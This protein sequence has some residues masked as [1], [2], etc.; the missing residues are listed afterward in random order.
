[1][2]AEQSL[3]LP[4]G[5][6]LYAVALP[7]VRE[8]V[9]APATTP[10]PTLSGAFLGLFNLRGEIVPLLDTAALLNLGVVSTW[11]F[12]VVV[13]SSYG[14]AGLAATALPQSVVL[15]E[16]VGPSE[17]SGT[18]GA[19]EVGDR[20]AVLLDVEALLGAARATAQSSL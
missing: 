10:L 6:D 4:V 8:V 9:P 14:P 7:A 5:L 16:P 3:L 2:T 20:L 15:G 19:Y 13:Q 1:M 12:V 17:S 11:P 18:S